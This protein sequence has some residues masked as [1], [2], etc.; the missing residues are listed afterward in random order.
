MF[1]LHLMAWV[2]LVIVCLSR[3]EANTP[4]AVIPQPSQVTQSAGHFVIKPDTCILASEGT[5]DVAEQLVDTL[6][7][8][9]GYRL[10]VLDV[11]DPFVNAIL[12]S[13]RPSLVG[14]GDEEY[15]LQVT[16]KNITILVATPAGLFY[17]V[18]TL[19]QLL[20][21][22][23]FSDQ[24]IAKIAWQ[25]PA[26]SIEDRPRFRWRGMHLDVA[27]HFMPKA[28]IKETKSTSTCSPYTR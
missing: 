11:Y 1:R 10:K 7:P 8:A 5:R 15:R 4:L 12:L 20:P 19:R 16:D 22:A 24:P 9:L 14:Y 17:G 21:A 27:R 18:Q 26:V 13:L 23:I 3:A 6:A 28:F 25:V 2:L